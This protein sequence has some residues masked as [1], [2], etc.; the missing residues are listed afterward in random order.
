[1]KKLI[2]AIAAAAGMT[3]PVFAGNFDLN[4]LTL[5][6]LKASQAQPIEMSL[7]APEEIM[8]YEKSPQIPTSALDLTI[9]LPFKTLSQRI[10]EMPMAKITPLDA[11]APILFKQGDNIA[12]SNINVDYNGI[13]V[14]PTIL[15]KPFFEGNNKLALKVVKIEAD[16]AFGPKAATPLDKDGLMEM[17]M[18]KLTTGM[19]ENIDKAFAK[20]KV[21][22]RAKDVLTFTYDRKAWILRANVTPKFVAPLLPGLIPDINLTGFSFDDLGFSMSVNAGSAVSIAKLPGYNLAMSDGLITNF[23]MQFTAGSDFNLLPGGKYDGGVKFRADGL[24]EVAGKVYVRSMPLKPNV[25][26]TATLRPIVTKDNTIWLR[27]E[28]VDVEKAYG[29][30]VPG[31]LN[32]WLQ[33]TIISNVMKT[34]TTNEALLKV[35]TCKKLDD[36]TVEMTLKNSAFL[37]SFAKGATIKYMKLGTGLMYLGFEL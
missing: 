16:V 5:S 26:F 28:R 8:G 6:D 30:G 34:I 21:P 15:I 7:P 17:V 11:S 1:M 22:L 9:K 12:L 35:M 19:L 25:Y 32:N 14:E 3:S 27:V 4:T 10:A 24:M 18:T 33:G 29:I 20:N 31:F 13:N 23:I 36:K 37:P 2:I